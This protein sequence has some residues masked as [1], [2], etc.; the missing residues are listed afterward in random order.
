MGG[1]SRGILWQRLVEWEDGIEKGSLIHNVGEV[2]SVCSVKKRGIK[3]RVPPSHLFRTDGSKPRLGRDE[4]P[5]R[6]KK[7][8]KKKPLGSAQGSVILLHFGKT[9]IPWKEEGIGN[10]QGRVS[11]N[12]TREW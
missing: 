1:F 2:T 4:E 8:Q 9:I 12:A 7:E 3:K 11:C 5:K 6:R 10:G